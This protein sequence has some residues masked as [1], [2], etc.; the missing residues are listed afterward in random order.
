M[1][2]PNRRSGMGFA[3]TGAAAAVVTLVPCVDV[4]SAVV[5]LV[6][7]L[8]WRRA[9]RLPLVPAA[10]HLLGYFTVV[11]VAPQ[12]QGLTLVHSSAQLERFLWDRGSA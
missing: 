2:T 6:V 11:K 12:A 4:V 7:L 10:A 3:K 1:S 9:L 5:T 8:S